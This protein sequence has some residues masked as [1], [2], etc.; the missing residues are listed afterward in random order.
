MPIPSMR[1]MPVFWA[2]SR[3]RVICEA[4]LMLLN[5]AASAAEF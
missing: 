2:F 5:E 4:N 3:V 1:R